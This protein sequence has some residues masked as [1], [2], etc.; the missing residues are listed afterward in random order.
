VIPEKLIKNEGKQE[1]ILK[2]QLEIKRYW[3]I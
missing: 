3:D 2:I 1:L